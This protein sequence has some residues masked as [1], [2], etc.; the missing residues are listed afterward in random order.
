MNKQVSDNVQASNPSQKGA[1]TFNL[2]DPLYK[3][4]VAKLRTKRKLSKLNE[5]LELAQQESSVWEE[6]FHEVYAEKEELEKEVITTRAVLDQYMKLA[7][8]ITWAPQ[9]SVE[10]LKKENES[11]ERQ[12]DLA[13]SI[14]NQGLEPAQAINW[15]AFGK[16]D[17][18]EDD[19]EPETE[20]CDPDDALEAAKQW[21]D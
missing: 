19:D 5:D 14:I 3:R 11:L 6:M 10:E 8:P 15:L 13:V 17:L 18:D 20:D 21:Q 7:G 2:T 4:K 12:L 9:K 16:M 1:A